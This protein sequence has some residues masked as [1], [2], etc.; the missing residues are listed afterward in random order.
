MS[1]TLPFPEPLTEAYKPQNISQF[2]GLAKQKTILANLAANPRPCGLLF[3]GGP[4]V[5]KSSMAFAF[6][7]AI[8]AEIHHLPSQ[9]SKLETLQSVTAM[10]HRVPYDFQTGKTCRFH[11]VVLDE[12]DLLS[13][14]AQNYLLSKLDGTAP[15]PSTFFILTA[16]SIEKFEDRLISRL[17]QLPKFNSYAAGDDIRDL[18]IRIWKDRAGGAPIP[19]FSRFPTS[20]PREA[21]QALEVT[22]LSL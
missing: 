6:A 19:D 11:V 15:C 2:V 5:G 7:R 22:L 21:L 8:D 13:S 12:A 14:A 3:W 4:G 20:N 18:L 1:A 17:I 10:C 16:N 9:D